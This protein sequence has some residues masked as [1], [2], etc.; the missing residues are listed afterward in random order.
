M[1]GR[2]KDKDNE[3]GVGTLAQLLD[4]RR[5]VSLNGGP[6]A[7]SHAYESED[8]GVDP[9]YVAP[10]DS[11][12][13][14]PDIPAGGAIGALIAAVVATFKRYGLIAAGISLF[15][16]VPIV[17]ILP[18]KFSPTYKAEAVLEVD[19]VK[20]RVLYTGEEW[21]ATSIHAYFNDYSRTVT[22][23][24]V[25]KRV[26]QRAVRHLQR[27][28]VPWAP[29]G[30]L[31]SE[32]VNHLRSR[33]KPTLMRETHLLLMAFEGSNRRVV[34][35]VINT[36]SRAFLREYTHETKVKNL[37]S[38]R[39]LMRER[40]RLSRELQE[41]YEGLD[42]LT[43]LIGGADLDSRQHIVYERF[44]TLDDAAT[45]QFLRR[46]EVE[47]NLV[48]AREQAQRLLGP[49]PEGDI[50]AAVAADTV[51]RDVRLTFGRVLSEHKGTTAGLTEDH[52]L[53]RKAQQK[54]EV[55][56]TDMKRIA[57]Q[58]QER[59]RARLRAEKNADARRILA[60][61]EEAYD[62]VV[63][64][65]RIMT[66][67]LDDARQTLKEHGRAMFEGSKLRSASA[68][69][70]DSID[71]V[72]RRIEEL[73]IETRAPIRISMRTP[74]FTPGHPV[75]DK[76]KL[77]G[78]VAGA[79]IWMLSF[80]IVL[81]SSKLLPRVYHPYDLESK[82]I[83]VLAQTDW[84]RGARA[85]ASMFQGLER[86]LAPRPLQLL[87]V[88]ASAAD[89][90]ATETAADT[91]LRYTGPGFR[92]F[93]LK[94]AGEPEGIDR[95]RDPDTGFPQGERTQRGAVRLGPVAPAEN[96]DLVL[97]SADFR[98]RFSMKSALYD[99]RIVTTP[100]LN[101]RIIDWPFF[102]QG[103][104]VIVVATKGVTK[105][106]R[107]S[108]TANAVRNGGGEIL[109]GIIVESNPAQKRRRWQ[110]GSKT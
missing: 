60:E 51:Y 86:V 27:R 45:K 30:M 5:E 62:A 46:A 52:P 106:G 13:E 69:L 32:R 102:R 25:E 29:D 104:K 92:A 58:V 8:D 76:G 83:R 11:G 19:P 43:P 70:L 110:F 15:L 4:V 7:T 56:R 34:A 64:S 22:H 88:P 65:E 99:V 59:V 47:G 96:L 63:H 14:P 42:V 37:H 101:G 6:S 79:A 20:P 97:T 12:F 2:G 103:Y 107:V 50:Q 49:L 105:G 82:E 81:V 109:G 89:A 55:A 16:S 71:T 41:T 75:S 100:P 108:T 77:M 87:F 18:S 54:I 39:L 10:G 80:G 93:H 90:E 26:I 74:A 40:R 61:A 24:A 85:A 84:P 33:I 78:V 23:L 38:Y 66:G 73:R 91:L 1:A 68:R 98:R 17:L 48:A 95:P 3:E 21:R 72:D 36:V 44:L 9:V 31:E 94:L 53:R 35:P 28:G 57:E 67:G